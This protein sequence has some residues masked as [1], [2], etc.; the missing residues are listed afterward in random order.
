MKIKV[1]Y[2]FAAAAILVILGFVFCLVNSFTGNPVSAF[3]A[4]RKIQN[5]AA[6][7]Y[8]GSDLVLSDVKYNFKNNAYGCHAQS[9][10]SEDTNF[11][12]QYSHGRVSDDYKYE[13][14]N[15]FTTYR[16]LSKD[17]N[18]MVKNIIEKDY[19]HETTLIIGD[20][21][22]DTQLLTPDVPLNLND[23]PLQLSLTVFILSDVR[24]EEQMSSSLLELHQLMMSKNISIDQ[25][26]L[27]LEEPMPEES[28]PGSGN[29]LYLEN[30]PAKNITANQQSLILIMREH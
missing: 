19:P 18:D 21:I 4:S 5:Y 2:F 10:K 22:G 26:T 9:P 6:V 12:I 15:H 13:V 17:F 24:N 16:R 3:V 27:R 14:A 11:Y 29:N 23:M 20:L 28:K 30:F 25:Y 1:R 8:P 7:H